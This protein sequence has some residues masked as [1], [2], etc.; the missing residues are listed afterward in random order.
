MDG[1]E[2]QAGSCPKEGGEGGGV[3]WLVL[4]YERMDPGADGARRGKERGRTERGWAGR[5]NGQTDLG[6][7]ERRRREKKRERKKGCVP[8]A[9]LF[10]LPV[11]AFLVGGPGL[12]GWL[13]WL[14]VLADPQA[15]LARGCDLR[16]F[17]CHGHR[18][19]RRPAVVVVV[20]VLVGPLLPK[21]CHSTPPC[22][23]SPLPV[24]WLHSSLSFC[25]CSRHGWQKKHS[26]IEPAFSYALASPAGNPSV[27]ACLRSTRTGN[28]ERFM[29]FFILFSFVPYLSIICHPL[30]H[31]PAVA[32]AP[33]PLPHAHHVPLPVRHSTRR[34]L[35]SSAVLQMPYLRPCD[36]VPC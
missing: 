15:I 32:L 9:S 7:R 4:F 2:W 31:L 19:P 26:T 6:Q 34:S 13:S 20:V 27:T 35:M 5:E 23:K 14:V 28:A 3:E 29:Q 30:K 18:R 12:A 11:G 33:P 1:G 8:P 22:S 36:P 10:P 16:S 24:P 21:T 17:L 25:P